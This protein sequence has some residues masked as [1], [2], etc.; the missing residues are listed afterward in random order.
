MNYESLKQR[1][2]DVIV[3]DTD[4]AEEFAETRIFDFPEQS[5]AD[6][7]PLLY[8]GSSNSPQVSRTAIANADSIDKSSKEEVIREVYCILVFNEASQELSQNKMF[9]LEDKIIT[10]LRNNVRLTNPEDNSDPLCTNLMV[11]STPRL[12][13]IKGDIKDGLNIIIRVTNYE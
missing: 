2:L 9:E 5:T 13:E 8:I 1:I 4:L 11:Y 3:A 10:I 7:Y 6:V 12:T